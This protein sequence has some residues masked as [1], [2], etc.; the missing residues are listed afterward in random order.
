[1]D[2]MSSARHGQCSNK[3]SPRICSF[4]VSRGSLE[5]SVI[6]ARGGGELATAEWAAFCFGVA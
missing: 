1:M 6:Y 5:F 4:V 2:L 3:I